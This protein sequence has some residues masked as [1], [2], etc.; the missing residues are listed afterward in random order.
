MTTLVPTDPPA[1]TRRTHADRHD[2]ETVEEGNMTEP[3]TRSSRH[4][5]VALI[6]LNRPAVKNALNGELM[7]ALNRELD[8]ARA[9]E[10]V[11]VVVLAGAGGV[12]CAGADVTAFDRM[13]AEP[14]LGP[15]TAMGGNLLSDMG[16]YAK[17]LI[18]AVEGV[19]LGG[20]C[21]LALA[22]DIVISGQSARFGLP[23]VKL[24][25]IPGGGGTQRL[26]Q[27]IGKSKALA[28]LLTGDF[29]PADKA[30]TSGIVAEVVDDGTAVAHAMEMAE[31]IAANSPL[32]VALAKDAALCALEAPLS[33]GLEREKRN[34]H[35]ALRSDD[36]REGESAFLEKRTANFTGS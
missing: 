7:A 35:I 19:A 12:F 11:R 2:T 15:R 28:M 6:E 1:Q 8:A 20:G 3:M 34:F 18:A 26:I 13:R 31:R 25:V 17:P 14:L 32:A 22:C 30:Y 16:V 4:G 23:E 24:G 36:C 33:Q 10:D 21:E 5:A 29:V 27:S 9:D